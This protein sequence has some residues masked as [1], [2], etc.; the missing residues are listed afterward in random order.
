MPS[1][2]GVAELDNPRKGIEV[3]GQNR[4]SAAACEWVLQDRLSLQSQHLDSQCLQ[5]SFPWSHGPPVFGGAARR[6]KGGESP[7]QAASRRR[8]RWQVYPAGGHT[9]NTHLPPPR[10]ERKGGMD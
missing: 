10:A 1:L 5:L 6:W 3:P 8:R 7:Y 9:Y 2:V 4:S